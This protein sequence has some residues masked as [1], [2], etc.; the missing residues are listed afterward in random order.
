MALPNR[1]KNQSDGLDTVEQI[2]KETELTVPQSDTCGFI[3][4]R[5]FLDDMSQTCRRTEGITE[6]DIQKVALSLPR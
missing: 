6:F 5:H 1:A 2:G 3:V 4:C